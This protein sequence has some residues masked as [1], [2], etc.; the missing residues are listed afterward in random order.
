MIYSVN[1]RKSAS[2]IGIDLNVIPLPIRAPALR[3]YTCVL[4]PHLSDAPEP[5]SALLGGLLSC[6][7]NIGG[8]PL[9]E[10]VFHAQLH[11]IFCRRMREDIELFLADGIEDHLRYRGGGSP[12]CANHW[13]AAW[14][15]ASISGLVGCSWG[16]FCKACG[17]FRSA[18]KMRVH[19]FR[20][21]DRGLE[22]RSASC[23]FEG[24][25]LGERD[26]PM[27]THLVD[28]QA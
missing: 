11:T 7:K 28:A 27:L 17:R 9:L 24:Q 5:A 19:K 13:R 26:D 4:H 22:L 20:A 10:N 23:Q 16:A 18:S 6:L 25:R 12:T 21:Q 2:I 1:H 8:H 15:R 3:E 14:S